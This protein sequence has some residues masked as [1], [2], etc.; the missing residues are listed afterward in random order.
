MLFRE[1]SPVNA[2]FCF[3]VLHDI[4]TFIKRWKSPRKLATEQPTPPQPKQKKKPLLTPLSPLQT[5][6]AEEGLPHHMQISQLQ[7][8]LCP[9]G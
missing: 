2:V 1:E 4:D 9:H 7:R 8:W 5:N 6:D 3:S